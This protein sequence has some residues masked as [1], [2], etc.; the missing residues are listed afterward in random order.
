MGYRSR[1]DAVEL[2]II[3]PIEAAGFVKYA[4]AS[5]DVEMIANQVLKYNREYRTF[6]LGVDPDEF[7]H[8]VEIHRR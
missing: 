2:E 8:Q 1:D 5:Y 7:W 3:A 4:R 6:D